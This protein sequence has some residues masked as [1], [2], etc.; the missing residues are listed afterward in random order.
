MKKEN[1]R[2]RSRVRGAPLAM[3]WL[4][5]AL[6]ISPPVG[7]AK[8]TPTLN[9]AVCTA[10]SGQWTWPTCTIPEGSNGVAS[11]DFK[12]AKPTVLLVRGSLT[13]DA[14][15][16]IT[17]AG[18]IV[19][20]N[21]GGVIPV[22]FGDGLM[23]GVLIRGAL[24]NAGS[25]TL[26]NVS[27]G[28]AG[29]ATVV[30]VTPNDP[31]APNRFRVAPGVLSNSG[32]IA[33]QNAGETQGINNLGSLNNAESGVIVAANSLTGSVGIRNRRDASL[34]SQ[35]YIVGALT[36]AGGITTANTGDGGSRGISNSGA[37]V[38]AATGTFTIGASSVS[39]VLAYGFRNNGSFTNF[40][41]FINNRGVFNLDLAADSTWGSYNLGVMIN[42]GKTLVGTSASHAGTFQNEGL[43]LNLG[44]ITSYGTFNDMT[45][46]MVNLGTFYNYWLINGGGNLGICVDQ[47]GSLGGC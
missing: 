47:P 44:E 11:A 8:P 7:A 18:S 4:G 10:I 34:G 39:D 21:S 17:N 27:P 3:A 23:V 20:E 28:T 12:I 26:Q 35:Y 33:I 25:I 45:G 14:G 46:S 41:T 42:Y 2:W 32:V 29:I 5:V 36:N 16:T 38:N 9:P 30:S 37:F 6:S 31:P 40:G 43:M 13:V 15:V 1:I 19:I 24:D 22:E